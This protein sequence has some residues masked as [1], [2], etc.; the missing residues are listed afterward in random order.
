M[1]VGQIT[2]VLPDEGRFEVE[3][4]GGIGEIIV[5]I[6]EGMAARIRMDT[7]LVH[8]NLPSG[9]RQ[10]DDVYT[11]PGY[12]SAANRVD[13]RVSLAMGNV[14]IRHSGGR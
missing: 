9:Y 7:A 8:R 11:S 1:G 12:D 10:R 6:P 4:D 5:V 3:I 14:L 13:L 2:V